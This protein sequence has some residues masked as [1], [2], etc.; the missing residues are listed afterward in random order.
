MAGRR[1]WIVALAGGALGLAAEAESFGDG[2]EVFVSWAAG[3][4]L[5]LTGGRTT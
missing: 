3:E 4:A 2:D 1:L 5:E